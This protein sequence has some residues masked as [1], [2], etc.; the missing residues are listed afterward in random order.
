MI[1]WMFL[2]CVLCLLSPVAHANTLPE[3]LSVQA[4]ESFLANNEEVDSVEEFVE[5][6][7]PLHKYF[8]ALV[9]DSDAGNE[10]LVTDENPR[11]VSWGGDSR[12]L[13]SWITAP[14]HEEVEFLQSAFDGETKWTA[15]VIDFAEDPPVVT[16]NPSACVACHGELNGPLWGERR[17]WVGTELEDT[18]PPSQEL[19]D[20]IAAAYRSGNPKIRVLDFAKFHPG[21]I[22][23]V[24]LADTNGHDS[25]LAVG[26]LSYTL[27]WIHSEVLA[28]EVKARENYDEIVRDVACSPRG[29]VD[30]WF[31]V[32]DHNPS[33]RADG[34]TVQGYTI[35]ST[36]WYQT[37]NGNIDMVFAFLV[38]YDL[39]RNRDDVRR[40]VQNLPN[41]HLAP[42]APDFL[43]YLPGTATAEQEINRYYLQLF[44]RRGQAALRERSERRETLPTYSMGNFGAAT[45]ELAGYVC[46]I[47]N[48]EEFTIPRRSLL[49]LPPPPDPERLPPSPSSCPEG[50]IG[51]PPDCTAPPPSSTPPEPEPMALKEPVT[52]EEKNGGGCAVA[53]GSEGVPLFPLLSLT[54]LV[55]VILM[56]P[57]M[58]R[59]LLLFFLL[60][61]P[62][63]AN[64]LS[65]VLS[66]QAIESFP[67]NNEEVNSV[68]GWRSS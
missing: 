53:S 40:L 15:G 3:A 6:L 20:K 25:W 12:F 13:I 14:D 58:I 10:E 45:R 4:I 17:P 29:A 64:T 46:K 21:V 66:V 48:D 34:P 47:L 30:R 68:E 26:E 23:H 51:T 42:S 16:T 18:H 41:E 63:H 31:S 32:A 24:E 55:T 27:G 65:E 38:L 7:P 43:R 11:V 60:A 57:A 44:G 36:P 50:Q 62:V 22:R 5:A 2:L 61:L 33:V 9:F 49:P 56:P 28:N 67:A 1:R 39:Y 37:G 8:F 54:A 59:T 19:L 35:D 52:V